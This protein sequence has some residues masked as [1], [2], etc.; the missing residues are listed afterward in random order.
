MIKTRRESDKEKELWNLL[1]NVVDEDLLD[2]RYANLFC[3]KNIDWGR[4]IL[5]KWYKEKLILHLSG[6]MNFIQKKS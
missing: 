5:Y 1:E 4:E 3:F 2:G 6:I